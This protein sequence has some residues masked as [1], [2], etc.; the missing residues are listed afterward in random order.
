MSRQEL[1][2]LLAQLQAELAENPPLDEALKQ[3]LQALGGNIQRV[4]AQ[5]VPS[6]EP[7]DTADTE[8]LATT[9]PDAPDVQAL[10]QTLETHLE[11]E[12]PYLVGTLRELVDRLGKMGI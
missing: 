10:V 5:A 3:S 12:H 9:P 11:A 4:L 1:S 7:G 8:P 2:A 6:A